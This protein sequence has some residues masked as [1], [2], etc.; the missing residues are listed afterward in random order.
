MDGLEPIDCRVRFLSFLGIGQNVQQ[1]AFVMHTAQV[2]LI[3]TSN[4]QW[5]ELFS[6]LNKY[7]SFKYSR[8]YRIL[9]EL[10]H[11][12]TERNQDLCRPV[13]IS[14]DPYRNYHFVPSVLQDIHVP[15]LIHDIS[16]CHMQCCGSE[17]GIRRFWP[18]I[19]DRFSGSRI[20]NPYVLELG[21]VLKWNNFKCC[22]VC[23]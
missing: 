20:P 4:V 15:R 7:L 14:H 6:S 9:D 21:P 8:Q 3:L 12:D 17:S 10:C 13:Y 22:E 1:A 5:H 19:R 16:I 18:R 23:G 2:V 11:A